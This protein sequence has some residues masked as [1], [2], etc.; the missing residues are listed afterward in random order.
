MSIQSSVTNLL[1]LP[2]NPLKQRR[3][4]CDFFFLIKKKRRKKKRGTTRSPSLESKQSKT[5]NK[6]TVLSAAMFTPYP[7]LHRFPYPQAPPNLASLWN[8]GYSVQKYTLHFTFTCL[9]FSFLH[10]LH[11]SHLL[12]H[13]KQ[14]PLIHFYQQHFHYSV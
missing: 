14:T 6:S 3:F 11:K 9:Y 1:L 5:L 12:K 4:A 10:F 13:A 2:L 7:W 8:Y